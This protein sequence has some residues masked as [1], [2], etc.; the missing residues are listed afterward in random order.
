MGAGRVVAHP[1]AKIQ[2]EPKTKTNGIHFFLFISLPSSK[3]HLDSV[4]IHN[5]AAD[6]LFAR[7][8]DQFYFIPFT[9]SL[10]HLSQGSDLEKIILE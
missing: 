10:L 2:S 7:K 6:F 9:A 1:A 4:G 8:V 5:S 3:I